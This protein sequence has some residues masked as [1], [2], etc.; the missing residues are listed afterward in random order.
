MIEWIDLL[1]EEFEEVWTFK[2]FELQR[3][4]I[5]RGFIVFI[6]QSQAKKFRQI[7]TNQSGKNEN[8]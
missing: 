3:L 5:C 8:P 7:D 2:T 6:I 1:R 4:F